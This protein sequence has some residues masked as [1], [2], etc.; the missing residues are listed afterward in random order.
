[1]DKELYTKVLG[2]M[3]AQCSRR[4]CCSSDIYKKVLKAVDGDVEMAG[5]VL[6][7]LEKDGFI[8]DFR[9][10]SAFAREKS[11]LNGWGRIKIAYALSAKGIDRSVIDRAFGET[12]SVAA[13]RRL[14]SLLA[15]KARSLSG[16]PQRRLKLIRFALGRGYTYD[17]VSDAVERALAAEK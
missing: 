3:Q 4:E 11:T 6:E 5:D 1:M 17:D 10:A 7:S 12:D 13:G 9:Y 8:D 2:R 16:D 14:D 15:S